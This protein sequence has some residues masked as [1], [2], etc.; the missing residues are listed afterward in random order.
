VWG[1]GVRAGD[2]E[3]VPGAGLHGRAHLLDHLGLR[4]HRLPGHVT[5]PLRRHLVLDVQRGH[6]RRVVLP[7][8]AQDVQVVPVAVVGV[9]DHR[10]ADR[11]YEP[12]R[13][14]DHLPE[15]QQPDVRPPEQ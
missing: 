2:Q 12:P 9:G 4:D 8:R 5:A 3:Q 14:V 1:A 7:H 15:R 11:L 10:H 6:P 13:L